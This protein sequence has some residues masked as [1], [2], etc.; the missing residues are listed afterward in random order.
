MMLLY[1]YG[2]RTMVIAYT[3]LQIAWVLVWW[4]FVH[5]LTGYRLTSLLKDTLPFAG[6]AAV[7]MI[8]THFATLPIESNIL[9][10]LARIVLAALLYFFIMKI[11]NAVI[12]KECIGFIKGRGARSKEQEM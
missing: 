12:L 1:P 4:W 5:R 2:V 8:V 11:A 7:V 3:L 10:L 9:L 6:T